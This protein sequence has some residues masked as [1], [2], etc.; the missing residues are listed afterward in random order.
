MNRHDSPTQWPLVR[1]VHRGGWKLT[2]GAAAAREVQKGGVDDFFG[3]EKFINLT[4]WLIIMV[5][6]AKK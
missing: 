3:E 2:G 6:M 1:T 5:N 4:E